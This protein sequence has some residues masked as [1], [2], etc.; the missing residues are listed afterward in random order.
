MSESQL[1]KAIIALRANDTES[2]RRRVAILSE[3]HAAA[4]FQRNATDYIRRTRA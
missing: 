3:A 4:F 1:D 2:N